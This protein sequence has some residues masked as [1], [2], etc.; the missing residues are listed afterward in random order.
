MSGQ[1]PL[2][3]EVRRIDITG[4]AMLYD[5][6]RVG[7]LPPAAFDP[8][9]WIARGELVGSAPGRGSAY[10][11]HSEGRHIVLRHYR[12][13]GLMA[14]LSAD[15]FLWRGEEL[16]RSFAEWQLTY[17]LHR[18]GLP[19]PAP[20]A[21]CYRRM[22]RTYTGD[23]I[24]ERLLDTESLA[25]RLRSAPLSLLQWIAIG[26]CIRRFHELGVCHAD[27]NAHNVLLG[28]D[29]TVYLVDFDRGS[30]RKP[31]LWCDAN[32]V[33]LRR[34]LEKITWGLPPERFTEADWQGLLDGY[35]QP[36][37]ARTAH[38]GS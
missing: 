1:W 37:A 26:R 29:D 10:F 2:G 34:S 8:Q 3:S 35:R 14:R 31:G 6:S 15:R 32:L 38:P 12:R 24:T 27:L 25:S 23:I 19:V 30:L 13:G 17:H 20:L 36:V 5:A 7:N 18:A 4:G 9:F 28:R 22:G 21:A 11:I 16:V 33:R